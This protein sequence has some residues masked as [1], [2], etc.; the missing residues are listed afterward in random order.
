MQRLQAYQ[1]E[2]LPN[3]EQRRRMRRFAGSCRFVFNKALALQ[4]EKRLCVRLIM[5]SAVGIP[6]L[7]E[8]WMS[9]LIPHSK[10]RR[11]RPMCRPAAA[12]RY[13]RWCSGGVPTLTQA[14]VL[15]VLPVARSD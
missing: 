7:Q 9:T 5:R 4:K 14:N 11:V 2:I 6:C 8:G 1:Y 12:L 3:D 15:G 13:A 10:I